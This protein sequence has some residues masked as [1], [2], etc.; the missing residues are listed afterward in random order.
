[1]T[2]TK[3][4]S[5]VSA[6]AKP[7]RSPRPFGFH[8]RLEALED[9][10]VPAFNLTVGTGTTSNVSTTTN[11]G[12]TTFAADGPNAFLNVADMSSALSSGP[13]VVESD[14]SGPSNIVI[15]P[16]AQIVETAGNLTFE[17]GDSILVSAG[18]VLEDNS[19]NPGGNLLLNIGDAQPSAAAGAAIIQGTL[20]NSSP[21]PP[22][23]IKG[24]GSSN[25]VIIDYTGGASLPDGLFY[26]RE[27]ANVGSTCLTM[28]DLNN[29][30]SNHTYTISGEVGISRDGAASINL[31]GVSGVSIVGGTL[32]NTF[33]ADITAIP[34][35]INGGGSG[36]NTI[37]FPFEFIGPVGTVPNGFSANGFVFVVYSNITAINLP[38][39]YSINAVYL[40]GQNSIPPVLDPSSAFNG[41]TPNEAFV[42]QVYL[43]ALGRTGTTAEL[44]SWV[45]AYFTIPGTTQAQAQFD[46]ASGIEKSPEACTRLVAA[47]YVAYLGGTEPNNEGSAW[48]QLLL[49]G[50][51]EEQVL[52]QFLATP[53]FYNNA[54][55]LISTGTPQQRYIQALYQLLLFRSGST[56]DVNLLTSDLASYGPTAVAASFLSSAEFRGD[57]FEGYYNAL[58]GRPADSA[59]LNSLIYN[60]LDMETV[61][62]GMES[63]AEFYNH[64]P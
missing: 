31:V 34:V 44:D 7:A 51:T 60:G 63:S 35:Q 38:V 11:S 62:V 16:S 61:R 57:L 18:S 40:P 55:T 23:E 54:Q 2:I 27:S 49:Q 24:F 3:R 36:A 12:T 26:F 48:V 13:V 32:N 6:L 42:Q 45:N 29:S 21:S 8:P 64:A 20:A 5:W 39:A 53:E 22:I 30:A 28:S 33:N 43:D 56:D 15:L 52:S 10:V 14:L 59:G 46:I 17:A 50:E 19:P 37:N 41:L 1:M 47:W 58:L 4:R 9:R 25:N